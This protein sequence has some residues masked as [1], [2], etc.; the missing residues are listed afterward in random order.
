MKSYVDM[1]N[2]LANNQK[3]FMDNLKLWHSIN[4]EAEST[5]D[6]AIVVINKLIKV[7]AKKLSY[8]PMHFSGQCFSLVSS[9][10]MNLNRLGIKHF[11]TIGDIEIDNKPYFK[12]TTASIQQELIDGYSADSPAVA[13]AWITLENGVIID[14]TLLPSISIH[15]SPV[16]KKSLKFNQMLYISDKYTGNRKIK[17]IP[18]FLGPQYII[19]VTSEYN[20]VSR[21]EVG[22]WIKG[23]HELLSGKVELVIK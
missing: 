22:N 19:R 23:I 3:P 6:I 16:R 4:T 18:L 5:T 8:R 9:A 17:H 21:A 13:H 7:L 14:M 11:V 10:S 2:H 20:E 1:F 12:T 15:M